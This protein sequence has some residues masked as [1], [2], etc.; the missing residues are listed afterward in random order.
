MK[1]HKNLRTAKKGVLF[2]IGVSCYLLNLIVTGREEIHK[3]VDQR[4]DI[5]KLLECQNIKRLL[6]DAAIAQNLLLITINLHSSWRH[7]CVLDMTVFKTLREGNYSKLKV[8]YLTLKSLIFKQSKI[9]ILC[10]NFIAVEFICKV[11]VRGIETSNGWCYIG[12]SICSRKLNRGF[13]LSHVLS[14]PCRND[15]TDT[16]ELVAFDTEVCKLTNVPA[17][18]VSHQQNCLI[19][20]YTSL[21]IKVGDAQDP[22]KEKAFGKG[23]WNCSEPLEEQQGV[24]PYVLE[25]LHGLMERRQKRR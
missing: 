7:L 12:C 15:A 24:C 6:G 11:V 16:A 22:N 9:W 21:L 3:I 10:L 13:H 1:S 4:N 19:H 17:A 5:E 18:D 23:V 25:R 14:V 2:S 8:N 20:Y